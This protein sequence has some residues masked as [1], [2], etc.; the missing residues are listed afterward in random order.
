M[1]TAPDAMGLT[2][3]AAAGYEAFF[4]PAIFDQWPA[5]IIE[6][7]QIGDGHHVLEHVG[8]GGSVTGFDLSESMLGVAREHCAAATFHQGDAADLPFDD[9]TFDVVVSSFMLMFTPD[10][11]RVVSEMLRVLKPNGRLVIAVWE[12]L[13]DN[14][15]YSALAEIARKHADDAAAASLGMPFALGKDGR[16]AGILQSAGATILDLGKRNGSAKFPSVESY[17]TTEIRAWV[18]ADSVNDECLAAMISDAQ[19]RFTEYRDQG[20]GALNLPLNAIV[21]VAEKS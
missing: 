3:E 14:P 12:S 11:I 15:A 8:A 5:R 6:Q 1:M 16:L 20:T 7:A 9:A 10:P 4:V 21:A 2:P 13:E 17:V 18:L 19:A